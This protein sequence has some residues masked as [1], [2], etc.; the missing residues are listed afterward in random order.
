MDA[1]IIGGTGVIGTGIVG[2]LR[3]RGA[4][5]TMYNRGRR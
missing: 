3:A 1:L 5:V 4:R 2:H